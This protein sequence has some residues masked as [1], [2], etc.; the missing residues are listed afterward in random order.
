M[1]DLGWNDDSQY[2]LNRADDGGYVDVILTVPNTD[3]TISP[4]DE[5]AKAAKNHGR[6]DTV[7]LIEHSV[8]AS[9]KHE[10][11]V[12][13][14]GFAA[15]L[16]VNELEQLLSFDQSIQAY[17][18]LQVNA[19]GTVGSNIVQIGAD[20]VWSYR[21]SNGFPVTGSGI[22]VA[23]IDTGV[24]YTHPDLGGGFGPGYRVVGGYDFYNDDA[25]PMD[26]NG[27]GTHVAGTIAANGSIEGVAPDASILAYKVLG[28]DGSGSMSSVVSAIDASVDPNGDG[29]LA[30]HADIIS[31]SLGA[32]GD[33]NDP[34]CL[35]VRAA[36]EAGVVVVVAAG[37]SGPTF[38]TVDSP[39]M[40]PEAITVGAADASGHLASFSSRGTV[41]DVL[42][43]PEL[44]APGVSILSTV[45]FSGTQHSSSSGYKNLSGTSMATPHVSGAAALLL[46][47][48]PQWTPEQV[49]SALVT[50][51][52]LMS[53]SLWWAGA[54]QLWAPTSSQM[55][56]FVTEPLVSYGLSNGTVHTIGVV[57]FG[58]S[59]SL[60][61]SGTD[62]NML[63]SN[64]TSIFPKWTNISMVSPANLVVPAS[65]QATM[66]LSVSVPSTDFQEGY[67]DGTIYLKNG[68][69][70]L[71]VSFGYAALSMLNVHVLAVD[72]KEVFDRNGG[73]WVFSIPDA[74][75][76]FAA[77]SSTEPAPPASFLIPSGVYSVFSLGHQLIYS[78]TNPYMLSTHITLNRF[79]VRDVYL[80]M[81]EARRMT[82]DL[83]TQDG[84]PV[85]VK[86]FMMYV[87]YSGN[88]NISFQ[89]TGVEPGVSSANFFTLPKSRTIYVSD[90]DATIGIS[91]GGFSYSE[92]MW[93]FM[94]SNG[95]N[96]Y[97]VREYNFTKFAIEP[98]ADLR[99]LLSW[100]FKGVNEGTPLAL[101]IDES[102]A[103]VY[104]SKYDI[105]GSIPTTWG[106]GPLLTLGE[107]CA[108]Y[109]RKDTYTAIVPIFSGITRK[110]VVQGAFYQKYWPGG[111]DE[112]C[113]DRNFYTPDYGHTVPVGY[114]PGV[115][116]PDQRFLTAPESGVYTDRVGSGP[117]YPSARTANTNSSLVLIYP[118]L[119]DQSGARVGLV[120]LPKLQ[121]YNSGSLVGSYFLE[122]YVAQPEP[123]RVIKLTQGGTYEAN[124]S[125]KGS[126]QVCT[127]TET[128]LGF[129]V[130]S[131]DPNPPRITAFSMPQR[132]VPGAS[133]AAQFSISDV[134][135][136]ATVQFSWRS[137]GTVTWNLLFPKD[138]GFGSYGVTFQTP[139]SASALDIK[140]KISDSKGNYI[141]YYA[142]NATLK[143]IP[144]LFD[145]YA[146][147]TTLPYVDDNVT[148][149]LT[150]RLTD[151][152]GNP[153][154]ATAAVPLE[155]VCNGEKVGVILDEYV[156][157]GS[158]AHDGTIRYEWRLNPT[159]LFTSPNEPALIEISFDLGIYEP[160]T[161]RI[162]LQSSDAVNDPPVVRLLSPANGSLISGGAII[163]LCVEDEGTPVTLVYLDGVLYGTLGSPWDLNTESWGDGTH[164]I[165]VVATDSSGLIGRATFTFTVDALPPTLA[166]LYPRD[167]GRVP[168]GSVLLVD[169]D[170]AHLK[171]V[172]WSVDAGPDVP[173]EA[174]Y[175]ID[176]TD[177]ATGVH[178][179][180]VVA[181]DT[182]GHL[183]SRSSTFELVDS[184]VV[185]QLESPSSGDVVRSGVPI[186]FSVTGSG[187]VS[188]RWYDG[189]M[190]YEIG[191][192]TQIPTAG[193]VEGAHA[194]LINST[195][196]L[197]GFDQI[198]ATLIMDDTA[199]SI[200]LT[201]PANNS[202]VDRNSRLNLHITE[203]HLQ[204]ADWE[205]WSNVY[206][207]A[208]SDISVVLSSS[209]RDGYFSLNVTAI[210][211][212][213]NA[214]RASYEFAMDNSPPS[215]FIEG[216]NEGDA[217]RP[218]HPINL[219]AQDAFLSSVQW[220]LDEQ[221]VQTIGTSY[222]ID[223]SAFTNGWHLLQ[224]IASDLSGKE[225]R[226]NMS[227]YVD[228]LSPAV[229]L[230]EMSSYA[231]NTSLEVRA[232]ASD[233]FAVKSVMLHV[234][235]RDGSYAM[236]EMSVLGDVYLAT[237]PA[238]L[239]W[240]GMS[241]YATAVDVAGN[242]AESPRVI[243]MAAA[244]PLPSDEPAQDDQERAD[245]GGQKAGPIPI[246][247]PIG[248]IMAIAS[249]LAACVVCVAMFVHRRR[250][251]ES[252]ESGSASA[253]IQETRDAGSAVPMQAAAAMPRST[254][255]TVSQV[256][257]IAT[258]VAEAPLHAAVPIKTPREKP[259]LM[260]AIPDLV[261]SDSGSEQDDIDYGE[262]IERE[263]S[264]NVLNRSV[265]RAS[266][267]PTDA[268]AHPVP[269]RE[270]PM[271]M[272]GLELKKLIDSR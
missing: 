96:W 178:T 164:T 226:L 161:R 151:T 139:T 231:A 104:L 32:S 16:Q 257:R 201:S 36:V 19:T 12:G 27:H 158:H 123:E 171:D 55:S 162:T 168:D 50:G 232:N 66:D 203:E 24:D 88:V 80:K 57:N 219:S 272:S 206:S 233:D 17:P 242:V 1:F 58:A 23:V 146:S 167:G 83:S 112:L 111:T 115:Y 174:P 72:G 187:I 218:G 7:S 191:T 69:F 238:E 176:M 192:A 34:L 46:Q 9:I 114:L 150:G 267:Q 63:N 73:V 97:Q 234:E 152:Q 204:V 48:H 109:A 169:V 77:T 258:K 31:M 40:A 131:T 101:R 252:G 189:T 133:I 180:V 103:A 129:A 42:M 62:R 20:Q 35:A 163:D 228:A 143:Q 60:V 271:V 76:R 235:Q 185:I 71:R 93:E 121:L 138:M 270:G 68:G 210:D 70:V 94:T 247:G 223:T 130:P 79:E 74:E 113:F 186:T 41:P 140:M 118:L 141:D 208:S 110:T 244:P 209:P 78:Y 67:Y 91:A 173:L 149:L 126:K 29:D 15:R 160:V 53:E 86:D 22:V 84:H 266:A 227:F 157:E 262:L 95:Q 6:S 220:S 182:V 30:D 26:D 82:L 193:W 155:L 11:S 207:T 127:Y 260:D 200:L 87:R 3:R 10:F 179:V 198:S 102:T 38:G 117:F 259:R 99:Y 249:V 263:L 254:A 159:H 136:I 250:P 216:V 236:I 64:G 172:Y 211:L 241:V 92:G 183:T 43:K 44:S 166:I 243:L 177:W 75:T 153:L 194:I 25:D 107:E 190:W 100:D 28:A 85:F 145:I 125:A 269:V 108:P 175:Q 215:V 148:V 170:D 197:G 45:P 154:S 253:L 98:T 165:E 37:N 39:G 212:A 116:L 49:K 264:L 237:I 202:F 195:N 128:K 33:Q 81:A 90:T 255:R 188:N 265:F 56:L 196:D 106:T 214:A 181:T 5:L 105:P 248:Q 122:E 65:G 225:S 47:L 142:Q 14:K 124:I 239:L 221:P 61:T 51:T 120:G 134:S 240:D 251:S 119:G 205:L 8:K 54:G 230:A 261:L 59:V 217:V 184:T 21:D 135:P 213:G 199:P 222:S 2:W 137:S 52:K 256:N 224:V 13:L 18:D 229:E 268:D 4:Y 132:F 245:D 89:L 246:S 144:V 156:T 147:P